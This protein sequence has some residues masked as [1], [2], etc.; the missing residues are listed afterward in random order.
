MDS[1]LFYGG[2]LKQ[3]GVQAL[4]A[5]AA[6]LWAFGLGLALFYGIKKTI[7]LRVTDEEER[8]S[9]WQEGDGADGIAA[10]EQQVARFPAAT[11][12]HRRAVQVVEDDLALLRRELAERV[13]VAHP[14]AT[15]QS[16]METYLGARS[17]VLGR[18][19]EFMRA[20]ARDGVDDVASVVVAVRR[21][22]SLAGGEPDVVR[23]G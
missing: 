13:L 6:F 16:A 23:T 7:G 17:V 5:G 22:R 14:D 10:L 15:A 12:W 3:L 4:G 1:G 9:E 21:I 20:L 2:G 19:G 8:H 11:R 18:L